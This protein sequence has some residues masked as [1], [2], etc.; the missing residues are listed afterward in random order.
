LRAAEQDRA[1]IA[2]AR[3]EWR[4]SQPDLNQEQFVFIDETGAKMGQEIVVLV[5][6]AALNRHVAPPAQYFRARRD[7]SR[8][9]ACLP[10]RFSS[11]PNASARKRT[12]QLSKSTFTLR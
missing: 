7:H 8:D 11:E 9:P 5:N 2:E 10:G 1:D 4:A 12:F 3:E 6:R